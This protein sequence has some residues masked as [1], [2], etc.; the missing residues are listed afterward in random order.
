MVT[1]TGPA[2]GEASIV[3]RNRDKVS[4]LSSRLRN[5][6]APKATVNRGASR[7]VSLTSHQRHCSI[8]AA[9]GFLWSRRLPSGSFLKCLTALVT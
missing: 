2:K 4:S 6:V 5:A 3:P 1:K 7:A 8:S 9:L